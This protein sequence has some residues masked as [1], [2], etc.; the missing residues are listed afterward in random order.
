[1]RHYRLSITE[2]RMY[3]T[4]AAQALDLIRSLGAPAR[5]QRHVE[6]VGEAGEALLE[7]LREQSVAVDE[8]FVRIGIVLH[9]AGKI[10]HPAE[11]NAPGGEHEPSGETMLLA[12]GVSPELARVCLS[13]A[14]WAAMDCRLEELAVALADK[15][16]KGVRKTELEERFIDAAAAV[17]ERDRWS[18]YL[19]LD[20][21]FERIAADGGERLARSAV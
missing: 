2:A 13:H 15:L 21:G 11:L 4:D 14:R 9:D 5:L 16:W 1:L 8:R 18:L 10:R 3:P 6:L 17:G 20:S 7:L 19:A 12:A